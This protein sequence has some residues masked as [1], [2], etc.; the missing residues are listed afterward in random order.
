[1]CV[2]VCVCVCDWE[3]FHLRS[4]SHTHCPVSVVLLSSKFQASES[5]SFLS[6]S[7]FLSLQI[8]TVCVCVC[9]QFRSPILLSVS[10]LMLAVYCAA[11]PWIFY[12]LL[13]TLDVML[14]TQSL[15]LTHS[16][17][18]HHSQS[19]SG[20][21][22]NQCSFAIDNVAFHMLLTL[23]I[24]ASLCC[25]YIYICVCDSVFEVFACTLSLLPKRKP[26]F[27]IKM[28]PFRRA[29]D[30]VSLDLLR[31]VMNCYFSEVS[32]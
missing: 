19:V 2:C 26:C 11:S 29:L 18:C 31:C 15:S 24:C 6:L 16:L 5:F 20:I 27:S 9:A 12:A 13:V 21:C 8:L 17:T 1:M 25:I 4:T 30:T 28:P 23:S 14:S 7:S 3:R 32:E 22:C 10:F